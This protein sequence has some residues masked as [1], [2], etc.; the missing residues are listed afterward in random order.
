MRLQVP[1]ASGPCLQR[2]ATL[3][4]GG[5]ARVEGVR[6]GAAG[7]P[8]AGAP[9]TCTVPVSMASLIAIAASTSRVNTQPCARRRWRHGH[10]KARRSGGQTTPGP[11]VQPT[12]RADMRLGLAPGGHLQRKV[13]CVAVVDSLL[14]GLHADLRP[15]GALRAAACACMRAWACKAANRTAALTPSATARQQLPGA[16]VRG[17]RTTGTIGPNGSSHASR[18]S[19]AA[20]ARSG[21]RRPQGGPPA[22]NAP[23]RALGAHIAK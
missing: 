1:G 6:E 3:Q 2:A 8:R 21:A 20:A 9:L 4:S 14:D 17:A 18:M 5:G 12:Q 19:C 15:R 23:F 7:A 11:S 10:C 22:A 13:V 16:R